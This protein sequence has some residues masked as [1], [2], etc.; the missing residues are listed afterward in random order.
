M[1]VYHIAK[2]RKPSDLP[3]WLF[4]ERERQVVGEQAQPDD[5]LDDQTQAS[6]SP[7]DG[8]LSGSNNGRTLDPVSSQARLRGADRLK[9]MRDAKREA[10][11]RNL[12]EN[13]P[14]GSRLTAGLPSGP[15]RGRRQ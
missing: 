15:Q 12:M 11:E 13:I 4:D 6:K 8:Q 14:N 2:A 1:K 10:A 9:A 5:V 3:E 7:E